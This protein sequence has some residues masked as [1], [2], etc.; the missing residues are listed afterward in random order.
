MS[1]QFNFSVYLIAA[2]WSDRANGVSAG[3]G[4]A[5]LFLSIYTQKL[6]VNNFGFFARRLQE[7]SGEKSELIF[8]RLSDWT[9]YPTFVLQS[10]T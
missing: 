1:V 8:G 9:F 10:I 7:Y 2:A 3:H 5:E 6:S 4:E